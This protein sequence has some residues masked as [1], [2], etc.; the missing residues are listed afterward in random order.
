MSELLV[1]IPSAKYFRAR[2]YDPATSEF[3]ST[4]RLE[5][6]DGRSLYRG[7]FV[8]VGV[9]PEGTDYRV[10]SGYP[11]DRG[12]NCGAVPVYWSGSFCYYRDWDGSINKNVACPCSF[13][14]PTLPPKKHCSGKL[15]PASENVYDLCMLICK[16]IP[17]ED[18]TDIKKRLCDKCK[19][20][21]EGPARDLCKWAC[22]QATGDIEIPSGK[23][24]VCDAICCSGELPKG[25]PGQEC[26][27]VFFE[28]N[29]LGPRGKVENCLKCCKNMGQPK[30]C[31][32]MCTTHGGG[33]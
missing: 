19:V 21:P 2:Y 29:T 26:L 30:N 3:I 17:I 24:L 23:E 16:E 4:D 33:F 32:K 14:K 15:S 12:D 31:E 1:G 27:K 22:K 13:I 9:D 8:T 10:G 25:I 18:P 11:T 20:L 7:Y 28:I 6:V 5:Y